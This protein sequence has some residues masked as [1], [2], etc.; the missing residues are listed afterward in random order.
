[1]TT[2]GPQAQQDAATANGGV[3]P[4]TMLIALIPLIVFWV[5]ESYASLTTALLAAMVFG[6]GESG[7]A[8]WRHG[9]VDRLT[10]AS[11]VLVLVTG[12]LGLIWNNGLLFKLK[13]AMIEIALAGGLFV[14]VWVGK[15]AMI[16]MVQQQLKRQLPPERLAYFRGV[17]WRM[18]LLFVLHAALTA[19]A[20][21][22]LSTGSW[23]FVK[24]VGSLVMMGITLFGE[25]VYIRLVLR[26]RWAEAA[27]PHRQRRRPENRDDD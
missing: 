25:M 12:A 1:M 20:A 24:G 8:Y 9:R 15:P 10:L 22:E 16:V 19:Y 18:A 5:V 6:I 4:A 14:S 2:P 17:T 21:L 27:P 13:P 23:I 26:I 11:T 7:Y 3:R